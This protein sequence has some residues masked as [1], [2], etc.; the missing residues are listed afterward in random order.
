MISVGLPHVR[1]TPVGRACGGK[2]NRIDRHWGGIE[3]S[4]RRTHHGESAHHLVKT[5]WKWMEERVNVHAD[6]QPGP[7]PES[8][9]QGDVS[10]GFFLLVADYSYC[11]LL[12]HAHALAERLDPFTFSSTDKPSRSAA[13]LYGERDYISVGSCCLVGDYSYCWLLHHAPSA[14]DLTHYLSAG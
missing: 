4:T 6:S 12:L 8:T 9:P 7:S 13:E 11:W 1:C 5:K 10:V 14:S 2:R 3:R